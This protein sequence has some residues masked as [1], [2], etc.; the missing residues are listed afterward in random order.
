MRLFIAINFE[1]EIKDYLTE[2]VGNLRHHALRGNF[3][4]PEHQHLTVIFIGETQRLDLAE[5][6]LER[7]AA[8]PFHLEL[9]G[10]GRF[11]RGPGGDIYWLGVRPQPVL[12]A[13]YDQLGRALTGAGFSI[14][15][16]PYKPHLTL[17]REV[18]LK[19]DFDQDAF[20]RTIKPRQ[21][22]VSRIS[23]MKSE[24]V[25]GQ[26]THTEIAAVNLE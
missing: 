8:P 20:A 7:V 16:R 9:A 2:V 24:R 18:V 4:R 10:F 12:Q 17:G 22:L 6:A 3:T 1:P 13:V 23:L 14:E 15:Q 19:P 25:K 26:L 11:R 21:L 5:A